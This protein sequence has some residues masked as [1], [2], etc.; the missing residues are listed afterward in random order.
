MLP[1]FAATEVGTLCVKP[2]VQEIF[3]QLFDSGVREFYFIVGRGKRAIEDHFTP[4]RE[5]VDLLNAQGKSGPASDL[6]HFYSRI[7]QSMIVWVNQPEPKGFGDAVLQAQKLIGTETF[8]VHAGDT[9]IISKGSSAIHRRLNGVHSGGNA[10]ATLTIQD[11]ADPREYGVAELTERTD[12]TF[13]VKRVVEKPTQPA[14]N[15]AIMPLYIF[16]AKIFDA[17]AATSPGK[18]GEVQ[19]TDAIQ[20][21]IDTRH[22][23]QA[24]KLYNDDVRIDIGTPET[25]WEAIG[26]SYRLASAE[27]RRSVGCHVA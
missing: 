18:G 3:E 5:S 4:E 10:N 14:S 9:F 24:I 21:L 16:D 1:V 15:H 7:T 12:G 6:E 11:V 26:L 8:L 22:T 20:K 19:L 23:V 17:L 27:C 25:Y 2:I 13:D